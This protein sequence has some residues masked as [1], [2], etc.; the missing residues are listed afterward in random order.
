MTLPDAG[1][2]AQPEVGAELSM[3][4]DIGSAWTK[5]AIVARSRGRW[6]IVSQVAQPSA[7]GEADLRSALVARLDG[8]VDRRVAS[9]IGELLQTAPRIACH[10][11]RRVG[12]IGLAGVSGELSGA[13]ARRAAES[14]G[15]TVTEAATADDGRSLTA[16]LAALQAADVD[17]WL[18]SGGFDGGRADQALEMAGLVATARSGSRQPVIWA[19]SA[20]LAAEVSALFEEGAVQVVDNPRPDATHEQPIPLRHELEELLQRMVEPGGVRQ[21]TPVSFRRA[22]AEL[23]RST[24]R[25]VLGVDLGA[26]YLTWVRS[27]ETG[28]AESRVFASGG[29]A[30]PA[31]LASGG[32]ARLARLL[33]MALDE[34]AVAD[35]LRN[36]NARPATLPQTDD[37][38]AVT[39]AA[40]RHLLS[41]AA[42]EGSITEGL[43]LL[44]GSGRTLAAAPRP[45]QA[46]QLLLDGIRPLG[47][48]ELAID[49]AGALPPIGALE[50]GEIGEGMGVLRDDLL[51]PLG[52]AVVPRG[53]RAGQVTMRV[54]V[55]RI[56]WPDEGPIDVRHGQVTVLPLGRGQSA[57]LDI[58]L[59]AS[60]SLGGPRS[61]RQVHATVTG[62]TVGLILDARDVP[63]AAP[64]RTD[65]R[66]AVLA[67]WHDAFLRE[68]TSTLVGNR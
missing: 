39:H 21:L 15:W 59:G 42:A 10:T 41:Q 61:G 29:L 20:D 26:R 36:L 60:V 4:V 35:A 14:A 11:P 40:A 43:D 18:I 55:H 31:L 46:A 1:K 65:D 8:V 49:T 67:A 62:G 47:I 45:A 34:L 5:A 13:S 17:A 68:P 24:M 38:L 63:L 2:T 23:A 57:E 66:R 16:R 27:D 64:R 32:S 50:D 28:D 19:G 53:G 6:R 48:T 54:S 22:I 56:G 37:E 25:S 7:W 33:P 9:R 44:I 12:R 3:L 30:S 52:V 51:V 58:E